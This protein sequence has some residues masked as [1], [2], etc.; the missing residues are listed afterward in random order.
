[1]AL[2]NEPRASVRDLYLATAARA[3]STIGNEVAV[4]ALLLRLHDGGGDGWAVAALLV[5]GTVPL[6]LLAPIA[7]MLADRYDSRILI[8]GG[9]LFQAGLCGALAFVE[10]PLIV[11]VLV[12]MNAAGAAVVGPTLTALVPALVPQGRLAM[13]MGLQEGSQLAA[14]LA[15]PALGGLLTGATGGATVPLLLDAGTFAVLGAAGALVQTRRRP[16]P[17]GGGIR[18]MAGI[19]ILGTDPVIRT[20]AVLL[21]LLVLVGEAVTVAEVFLV[22]DTL[23]AG[24]TAFGALTAAFMAGMIAGTVPAFALK[25]TRR[26]LATIPLA[27]FVM[28]AGLIGV[29]SIGTLAGVFVCYAV[30]GVGAGALNVAATTLVLYRTPDAVRGRVQAGLNGLLRSAGIGALGVGGLAV[31]IFAPDTVFVL[32]GVAIAV[33]AAAALPLFRRIGG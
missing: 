21:A 27:S 1:M 19:L 10:R 23:G 20:V 22:R 33:A 8:V 2:N 9:S 30:A 12:A 5:A 3:V 13:A 17:S 26:I 24:A 25:T 14:V 32:S 4:I 11:L 15:G 6:V 28:A 29:G 18:P 7:G 16:S 31:G